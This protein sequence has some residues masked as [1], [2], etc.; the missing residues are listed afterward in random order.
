M[1]MFLHTMQMTPTYTGAAKLDERGIQKRTPL[2]ASDGQVGPKFTM[3]ERGCAE[4]AQVGGN[5]A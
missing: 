5:P 1:H 2:W 3:T 4:W